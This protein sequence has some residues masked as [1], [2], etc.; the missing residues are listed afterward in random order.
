MAGK[1]RAKITLSNA[2]YP[3]SAV[4]KA[5]SCLGN[6]IKFKKSVLGGKTEIE[7]EMP[8]AEDA[9]GFTLEFHNF[10]LAAI[11]GA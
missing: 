4:Q 10:L 11:K 7:F 5:L 1:N 3:E 8:P 2:I 9:E 6:E